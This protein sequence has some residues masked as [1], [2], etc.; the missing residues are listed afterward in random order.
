MMNGVV[1]KSTGSWYSV[2][3]ND[4]TTVECR[5]RGRFR[6]SGIRL[7]NP[8]AVGD[9]VTVENN[10]KD[11][12]ITEIAERRNYI[13]RKSVNLSKEA[14]IIAANLDLA[15]MVATITHPEVP[16]TFIDRFL[17]VAEAYSIP[18]L[19][20]FNKIDL[21]DEEQNPY[22]ELV[23]LY[24][25]IGYPCILTSATTGVGIEEFSKA[26]ASKTVLLS[27]QSGV[28]K[29]SLINAI[30][31]ELD[32]KTSELSASFD[33]GRHTTTFAEMFFLPNGTRL[34]DTP[35]I[36]GMG[37]VDMKQQEISHY[38]PEIFRESEKCRYG[39][40]LHLEEPG[41]A[42]VQAVED[43]RIAESRYRSYLSMLSSDDEERYRQ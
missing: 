28:G 40:C 35:G 30:A 27:G 6:I 24:E 17:A 13:I 26:I 36:R 2:R 12:I 32:L 9:V 5:I 19:L 23:A 22:E 34:I 39:N 15:V 29:S 18:A 1:I 7:T 25:G 20:V 14:H 16:T 3:L 33:L 31:P 41:C 42:V 37:M 8:V 21:Y 4:G 11:Y 38:F 10:G 43:G